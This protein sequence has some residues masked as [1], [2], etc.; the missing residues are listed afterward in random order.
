MT[1]LEEQERLA[2]A[3]ASSQADAADAPPDE[4]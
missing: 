2:R 3:H 4:A 1:F